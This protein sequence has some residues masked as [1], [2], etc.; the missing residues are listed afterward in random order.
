[1]SNCLKQVGLQADQLSKDTRDY[2]LSLINIH[3]NAHL[4]DEI[5]WAVRSVSPSQRLSLDVWK[6]RL[7]HQQHLDWWPLV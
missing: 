2:S 3:A 7:P 5:L 1:M 6:S 4:T